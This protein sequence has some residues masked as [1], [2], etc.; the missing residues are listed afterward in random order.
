MDSRQSTSRT[1]IIE[2]PE[3]LI[4][5]FIKRVYVQEDMKT[6]MTAAGI[7]KDDVLCC[8][9][10]SCVTVKAWIDDCLIKGFY[11][12]ICLLYSCCRN[13]HDVKISLLCV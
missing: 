9:M 8:D 12:G 5:V 10:G 4:E 6:S 1:T 2:L 11:R 13:M 3:I 7:I